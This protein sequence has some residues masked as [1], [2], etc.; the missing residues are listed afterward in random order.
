MNARRGSAGMPE[1]SG[2]DRLAELEARLERLESSPGLKERGRRLVDRVMPPEAAKHFRNAGREELLGLRA[3]VDYWL[4]WIDDRE[5]GG[6]GGGRQSI[7][8]E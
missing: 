8:V 7:E 6:D 2:G 5:S 1:V 3:I 4:R